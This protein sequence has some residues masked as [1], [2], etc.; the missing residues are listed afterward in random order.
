MDVQ[1]ESDAKLDYDRKQKEM[2]VLSSL[3]KNR[4]RTN[5][6]GSWFFI[7]T[8]N[9]TFHQDSDLTFRGSDDDITDMVRVPDC[10]KFDDVSSTF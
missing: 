10:S 4:Y 7:H 2:A 6:K 9:F 5:M 8:K 3:G 1:S